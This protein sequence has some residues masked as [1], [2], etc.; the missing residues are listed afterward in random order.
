MGPR[1]QNNSPSITST[2][3]LKQLWAMTC[4]L[5]VSNHHILH[6]YMVSAIFYLRLTYFKI[7]QR[8]WFS[9]KICFWVLFNFG[10]D[11]AG[12]MESHVCVL[13]WFV[14]TSHLVYL[15]FPTRIQAHVR[16]LQP[17]KQFET[18][19]E[20]RAHSN[21]KVKNKRGGHIKPSFQCCMHI[22]YTCP[23]VGTQICSIT[24][25]EISGKLRKMRIYVEQALWE[26]HTLVDIGQLS[27]TENHVR[28]S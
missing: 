23:H 7:L 2:E 10:I 6:S 20:S 12:S 17:A 25:E 8:K 9:T 18:R 5:H 3:G 21:H 19:S 4:V 15:C 22:V 14:E 11:T 1:L 24:V 26:S 28:Y 27:K 13:I 16:V